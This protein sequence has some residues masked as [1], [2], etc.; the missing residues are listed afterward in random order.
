MGGLVNCVSGLQ[1]VLG[2]QM[3]CKTFNALKFNLTPHFK[4]LLIFDIFLA[5]KYPKPEIS[6][7]LYDRA[8]IVAQKLLE[9]HE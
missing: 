9:R 2:D 5:N 3:R 6:Y 8:L 1:I 7:F 4:G